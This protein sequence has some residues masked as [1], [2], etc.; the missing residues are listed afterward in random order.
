MDKARS[1]ERWERT[2]EVPPIESDNLEDDAEREGRGIQGRAEVWATEESPRT[3]SLALTIRTYS[4]IS[5]LLQEA[6]I[7]Q[8]V[9]QYN[10]RISIRNQKYD[11]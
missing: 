10:I 1:S 9:Y 5:S 4:S 7:K 2:T 8:W 6:D 11:F 3:H